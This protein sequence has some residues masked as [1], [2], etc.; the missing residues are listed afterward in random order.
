MAR[1]Y[2]INVILHACIAA[3]LY[4]HGDIAQAQI[5][6]S[7]LWNGDTLCHLEKP[8]T[9]EGT[10]IHGSPHDTCS[11]QINASLGYYT[12]IEIRNSD[13]INESFLLY[14]ERLGELDLC[15]N[16]YVVLNVN[17]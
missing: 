1:C 16:R 10:L 14:I 3:I 13:M 11:V 8:N 2:L 7:P 6:M 9:T 15:T 17:D 12:R 5:S 4:F